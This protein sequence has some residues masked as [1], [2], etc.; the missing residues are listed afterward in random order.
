MKS[1][2][3]FISDFQVIKQAFP[4]AIYFKYLVGGQRMIIGLPRD[5]MVY[6]N[7][8]VDIHLQIQNYNYLKQYYS[9]F[10]KLK[11]IDL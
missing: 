3:S 6:I 2:D 9:E 11:E 5:L 8:P 10:S 7:F 4:N 1:F